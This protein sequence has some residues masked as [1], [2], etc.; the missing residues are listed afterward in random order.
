LPSSFG[1]SGWEILVMGGVVLLIVLTITV[2]R[3]CVA[4]PSWCVELFVR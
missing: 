1:I 2:F 3:Y 4:S